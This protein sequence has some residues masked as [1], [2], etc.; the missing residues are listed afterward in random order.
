MRSTLNLEY[1]SLEISRLIDHNYL[2]SLNVR[3][4][5]LH[6]ELELLRMS[7]IPGATTETELDIENIH[8]A[9]SGG[10]LLFGDE[11]V[12]MENVIENCHLWELGLRVE[13][14]QFTFEDPKEADIDGLEDDLAAL[15][16]AVPDLVF[17]GI[18]QFEGDNYHEFR[19]YVIDDNDIQV[20]KPGYIVWE[21]E[22]I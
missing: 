2:S 7:G 12:A 21:D 8:R 16:E 13:D 5:K 9:K 6:H 18:L 14:F 17:N 10:A 3:L 4:E 19:R 22:E 20:Q 15:F 1:S 11:A